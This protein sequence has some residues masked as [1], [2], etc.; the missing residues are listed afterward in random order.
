M[1]HVE[2]KIAAIHTG[3]PLPQGETGEICVRGYLVMQ[4]FYKQPELTAQTIDK[5]GWLHTGDLAYMDEDGY[6]VMKGRIK[7]IIIRGGENISPLEVANE[8]DSIKGIADCKVVGVP[9]THY[10]E[11]ACA[12]VV[13]FPGA[14][15]S[16]DDIHE[17]LSSRLAAYKVPKY[18]L[19]FD[20]LPLNSTGKVDSKAVKEMAVHELGLF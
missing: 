8:I 3:K 1:D 16:A 12:C 4:G 7:D 15:I 20:Q 19:F 11:E 14:E 2:G 13:K 9:D 6:L 10:G 5:D 18:V 17:Y